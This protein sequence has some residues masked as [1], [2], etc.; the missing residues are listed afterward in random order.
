MIYC[1]TGG[2]GMV[3]RAVHK[4]LVAEGHE[5]R[6][7]T[8]NPKKPGEFAWNPAKG[9]IDPAA[10]LGVDGI[11]HLAGASVSERWTASHKKAI[12]ESRVQGAETLYRAVAAMDVRPEV[13]ISASA[14]GIYPNSYDR[15]YT[16]RDGGA[17]GFLGDVVRAWEAQAD[18][19][20]ALGLRVA[21]L[22]IGIVLGQG[23]GVLATLLPLFRLGLGSALG[24]GRQW[25][26][27]IHVDDLAQMC[28]RLASDRN[29]SGV[30]NG[31]G[32]ESATNLEFSRTL[33]TVLQKPFWMPA[34][35]AFALRWVLGEMAQIALM[36]T[37]CS[38]E[39]WRAIGFSYRYSDLRSALANL[40]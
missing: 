6:I 22:R 29:L 10:L 16:E 28:V 18:R 26:P 4:A 21:K 37:H 40:V 7:L 11:I 15:V 13:V 31:V 12:M 30:W 38:A 9:S 24:S 25:M 5:V 3:G 23:G 17:A 1:I 32:P 20:E 34:P 33:A 35:P 2:S 36:S 27:W 14:V 8:R 39:K 19:F